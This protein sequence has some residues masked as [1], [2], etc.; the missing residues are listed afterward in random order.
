MTVNSAVDVEPVDVGQPSRQPRPRS[1]GTASNSASGSRRRPAAFV[2]GIRFY[3]GF[4]NIG[5]HIGQS[6]DARP[7]RCWRPA[8]PSGESLSGWQTVTFSPVRC[9]SRPD[10]TYVA[11]YHTD[12][13]YS[14]ERRIISRRPISN[15]LLTVQPGGGVYAYT[16]TPAL[17]PTNSFNASNYWVDVVFAAGAEHRAGGNG[18]HS[19]SRSAR[20]GRWQSPFA[21]LVANDTD[22]NGD[23]LTITAVGN[24]TNGTVTLDAQTG[25][26]IFTPNAGYSGPASFT[27]TV[28]DG[29][30]GTDYGQCQPDGRAGSCRRVAVPGQRRADG[31]ALQ[32]RPSARTRHEVHRVRSAARSPASASTRRPATP[33]RIPARCGRRRA[34]CSRTVTFTNESTS[35]WQTATFSNP[36]AD[37][38]GTTYIAS[39]HTTGSLCGDRELFHHRHHQRPA[40]RAVVGDERRQRRLRLLRRAPRFPTSSYQATNYWVDVVFN[41]STVNTV[42]VANNDNGFTSSHNTPLAVIAA[43]ALLANDSDPDGD[44]LTITGV[45]N[46]HNGTVSFNSADRPDH[47]HADGRL[48]RTGKLH[49]RHIG[50][51]RRNGF[52]DRQRDGGPARHD[53]EP[54]LAV[55]HAQPC[56]RQ[57]LRLRR[58]RRQVHRVVARHHHRPAL[59]QERAGHRHAYRLAVDQHAARCLPRAT[60][61]N[62]T[63][64]GWQTVTFS[65]P[66]TVAA[67]TTYVA[68]YHS[69]GFYAATPNYFATSHTNGPLTAPSSAASGGNGVY[70]LRLEQPV[71]DCQLQ[72]DEL[73]GRCA[74]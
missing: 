23:A 19:G 74:L 68:S 16:A 45:D 73:L 17:F 57:R 2:H 72:R 41:Q 6:V 26:V 40:D 38:A 15:G 7:A 13:Y 69:N 9:I 1:T 21:A 28:S 27:Y 56:F 59:L 71:P 65:Q 36:V 64:S 43:A 11:S 5:E 14:V 18:R 24:A 53:G 31:P 50:R 8:S 47:V 25:N 4:Y 32:R 55:R 35:G 30:G 10:T 44:P 67:G 54:V 62:E 46:A 63:A 58:T 22:P 39:Y 52:G 29:R 20:T 66:I 34:R 3:K 60:F 37:H 12:G 61:T 48:H 42:P 70:R 33:A 49:L 51:P